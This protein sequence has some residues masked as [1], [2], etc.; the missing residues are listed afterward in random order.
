MEESWLG[1]SWEDWSIRQIRLIHCFWLY[2]SVMLWLEN[3]GFDDLEFLEESWS[4]IWLLQSVRAEPYYPRS[5]DWCNQS[6]PN[7]II[8]APFIS[9]CDIV[10]VANT[11]PNLDV[12]LWSQYSYPHCWVSQISVDAY[13]LTCFTDNLTPSMIV[14]KIEVL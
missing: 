9:V 8:H 4:R 5:V 14:K 1:S 11:G 6:K 2:R 12:A 7:A 10:S 13:A 3:S